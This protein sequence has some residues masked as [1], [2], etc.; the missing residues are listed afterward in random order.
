M[1]RI[2]KAMAIMLAMAVFVVLAGCTNEKKNPEV[3]IIQYMEHVALDS[4]LLQL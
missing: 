3:G 4:A 1:K 2:A